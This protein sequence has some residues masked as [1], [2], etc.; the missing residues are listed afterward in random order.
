[1]SC[2]K[3]YIIICVIIIIFWILS[4]NIENNIHNNILIYISYKLDAKSNNY[5][6]WL[7]KLLWI[8]INILSEIFK[9]SIIYSNIFFY[10]TNNDKYNQ[11]F[12]YKIKSILIILLN[13]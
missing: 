3:W 6:L 7:N 9:T 2:I 10:G 8:L 5:G 4:N 11:I 12:S 13:V 1:M